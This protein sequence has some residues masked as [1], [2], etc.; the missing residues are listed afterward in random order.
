MLEASFFKT[1]PKL[2]PKGT[3]EG[4]TSTMSDTAKA[5]GSQPDLAALAARNSGAVRRRAAQQA[6]NKP[7]STRAAG[8]GGSSNTMMRLYTDDNAGL[9]VDPVV[10]LVLAVSFVFSVVLLH[11]F[12]K[13]ARFLTK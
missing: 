10:V 8:A 7:N 13:F 5:S 9:S 1:F 12:G 2:T 6:A 11:I 3:E 4:H